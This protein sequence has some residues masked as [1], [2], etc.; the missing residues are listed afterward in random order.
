M[1]DSLYD[2]VT[3]RVTL[4]PAVRTNGT[5]NGTAVDT[6]GSRN[7]FR[8]AMLL[9]TAGVITDGT[10]TVQLQDSDDGTTNWQNFA[11]A[12]QGSIPVLGTPQGNATYR[13]AI[14]GIPRRYLRANV[15]VAGATTGGAVSAVIVLASG[16]GRAVT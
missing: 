6:Q 3:A 7:F 14:D 5:V 2:D 13:L 10:Q 16:S 1:R 12:T 4:P 11:G 9:V 8:V 15:T